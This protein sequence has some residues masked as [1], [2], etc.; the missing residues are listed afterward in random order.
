MPLYLFKDELKNYA[1]ERR[2]A[3]EDD[4]GLEMC[5]RER[6]LQQHITPLFQ[7]LDSR[8]EAQQ[9]KLEL[10]RHARGVCTFKMLWLLYKPGTIVYDARLVDGTQDP[11]A[12]VIKSVTGG[13]GSI[14]NESYTVVFWYVDIGRAKIGRVEHVTE[15]IPFDGECDIDV[16]NLNWYPSQETGCRASEFI[17]A[18]MR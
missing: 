4:P 17:P 16:S 9:I 10:E 2:K 14:H 13:G 3:L 5:E 11:E 7:F 6:D 8:P 15:I 1:E 12:W 18:D